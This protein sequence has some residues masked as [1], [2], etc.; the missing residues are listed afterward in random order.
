MLILFILD[1]PFTMM[2]SSRSTPASTTTTKDVSDSDNGLTVG[3]KRN[4]DS[5]LSL[6]DEELHE[7]LTTK[8]GPHQELQVEADKPD[9]ILL[10]GK[11][12]D[13]P[14]NCILEKWLS[15]LEGNDK[16]ATKAQIVA[17]KTTVTA[18]VQR[19]T[20]AT[21]RATTVTAPVQRAKKV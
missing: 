21:A 8:Y 20:T 3:N 13:D 9:I 17:K 16:G 11:L 10:R 1:N 19:A 4:R 7:A 6:S 14:G 18:P 2:T 12:E 15:K 5:M